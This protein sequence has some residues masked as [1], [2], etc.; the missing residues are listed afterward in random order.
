MLH[1]FCKNTVKIEYKFIYNYLKNNFA[2]QFIPVKANSSI[3]GMKA[4]TQEI[5]FFTA[6]LFTCFFLMGECEKAREW[7]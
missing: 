7:L 6:L 2:M 5:L 3:I 4:N 1:L